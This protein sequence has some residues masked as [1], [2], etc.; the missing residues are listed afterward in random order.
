MVTD[1]KEP[2]HDF[3]H[4]VR[5]RKRPCSSDESC[6][7]LSQGAGPT[8]HVIGLP[9][10]FADTFVCLGRRGQLASLPEVA[11]PPATFVRRRNVLPQVATGRVAPISNHN[12]RDLARSTAP[13]PSTTNV[14]SI[15]PGQMTTIGFQNIFELG[16]EVRLFT[17]RRFNADIRI[18]K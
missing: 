18:L 4:A 15:F 7:R 9:A 2:C 1:D 17:R 14:C 5:L 12:D 11:A 16:R 8:F 6:A 13:S 3:V 10:T